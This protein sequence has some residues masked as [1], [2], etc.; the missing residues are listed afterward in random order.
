MSATY[1]TKKIL[2]KRSYQILALILIALAAGLLLIPKHPKHEGISPELFAK[3][4]LSTERYI[5]SDQLADRIINQ[6]PTLLLIDTRL[7][8]A[9]QSFS[10]PN[11]IHIPLSE[12][13]S[14]ELNPYLDQNIYDIILFSNDNFNAEQAWMLCNRMDYQRLYIL[15]GGLNT[16]FS[17]IIEPIPPKET[18]SQEAFELYSF[19]RAAGKY[20]GVANDTVEVEVKPVRKAAPKKVVTKPKKKKRVPEGGC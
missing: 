20:F 2:V 6:D 9:Y 8:E 18:M 13:F 17:T 4:I 5:T 10:L 19:R 12:I 7:L 3:N 16:W 1:T 15:D 14:E 11:A